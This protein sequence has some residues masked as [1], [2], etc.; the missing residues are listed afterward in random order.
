MKTLYK[1]TSTGK[2]QQWSISVNGNEIVTSSGKVNGKMIISKK[3]IDIGKNIGKNNE[4][5]PE[6]QALKEAKAMCTLKLKQ[7]YVKTIEKAQNEEVNSIISGGY[8]P[9]LAK[10]FDK[11]GKHIVFPCAA[12]PKL[13]G[14][15]GCFTGRKMYSRTRKPMISVPHITKYLN[16]WLGT[17][18]K[19]FDGELYNHSMKDDFEEIVKIVNQK[20]TPSENHRLAQYHIYDIPMDAPFKERMKALELLRYT[21]NGSSVVVVETIIVNNHQE[22]LEYNEKKVA[23][24]YEGIMLRN[25]D[26]PYEYKRSKHLQKVKEFEDAEF[27]ITGVSEGTGKLRGHAGAFICTTESGSEF[28]AKLKGKLSDLKKYWEN[29]NECIGKLLTVQFQGYTNKSSVPRFPVGLRIRESE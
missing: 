3:F 29:P 17:I 1:K 20:T 9:M 26:S 13:D 12:Q 24:G 27:K 8:K 18:P 10:S 21:L 5:T 4:T 6:A 11:D 7:G 28:K 2:I 15:R 16:S 25:L 19:T 23:E 14:I 22:M